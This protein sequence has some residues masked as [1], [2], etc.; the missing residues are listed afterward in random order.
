[1]T[2][3]RTSVCNDDV[4][5]ATWWAKK[6]ESSNCDFPTESCQFLTE[7]IQKLQ[8]FDFVF[9]IVAKWGGI[10]PHFCL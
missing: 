2:S 7:K 5:S 4:S 8:N 1:M 3:D 10:Q 6:V 9:K